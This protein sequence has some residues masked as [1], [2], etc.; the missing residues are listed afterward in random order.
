[1][2]PLRRLTSP[3]NQWRGGLVCPR[4]HNTP[5]QET[6]KK[7]NLRPPTICRKQAS[8]KTANT[9]RLTNAVLY[10]RVPRP[11]HY[12]DFGVRII[13]MI[14]VSIRGGCSTSAISSRSSLSRESKLLPRSV[15]SISRPLNRT[16]ARTFHPFLRKSSTCRFLNW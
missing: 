9:C 7:C 10:A 11:A 6:L 12:E 13:D 3:S 1:M 8:H 4:V 14:R 16:V 5:G 15:W 2:D